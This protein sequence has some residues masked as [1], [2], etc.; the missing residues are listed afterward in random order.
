[1]LEREVGTFYGQSAHDQGYLNHAGIPTAN[2]GPGE[3]SFAHTDLDL[4]SVD[5]V[6]DAAKVYAWLIAGYL[7][8]DPAFGDDPAQ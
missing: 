7:G 1:M 4:A 6:H 5:K 2:F 3:Q 8:C